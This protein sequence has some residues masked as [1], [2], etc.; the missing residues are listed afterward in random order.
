MYMG[1]YLRRK[2]SDLESRDISLV[3]TSST[4]ERGSPFNEG[5]PRTTDTVE[6]TVGKGSDASSFHVNKTELCQQSEYFR[7]ILRTQAAHHH[8]SL[9]AEDPR[10]F[11]LF[12]TWLDKRESPPEYK[13]NEYS[14][15][16]WRSLAAQAYV[17]GQHLQARHF[18]HYALVQ[19]I[20]NCALVESDTW[21]FIETNTKSGQPLRRFSD[22][23]IAWNTSLSQT[24]YLSFKAASFARQITKTTRDPRTYLIDHWDHSCA[25][26]LGRTC[27]H[28]VKAQEVVSQSIRP[29]YGETGK[30]WERTQRNRSAS[31]STRRY[32]PSSYPPVYRASPSR[33]SSVPARARAASRPASVYSSHSEDLG[34]TSRYVCHLRCAL[35]IIP[36]YTSL[37]MKLNLRL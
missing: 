15:E 21:H 7:Q 9:D 32:Y 36:A 34:T 35:H 22:H 3:P 16:P 30:D 11:E 10:T 27:V 2:R 14:D 23:W 28:N 12:C 20:V 1:K 26:K 24:E 13:P 29:V 18:M 17:L 37:T 19:F 6:V 8:I 5:T 4:E 25:N 33:T 31:S